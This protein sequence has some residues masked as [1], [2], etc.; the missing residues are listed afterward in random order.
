MKFTINN[1]HYQ[2]W[3]R[4]KEKLSELNEFLN[5]ELETAD[6]NLIPSHSGNIVPKRITMMDNLME[7][8]TNYILV[9]D[10][11]GDEYYT[12]KLDDVVPINE[13]VEDWDYL[14]TN[15]TVTIIKSPQEAIVDFIL[16]ESEFPLSILYDHRNKEEWENLL[17]GLTVKTLNAVSGPIYD[18]DELNPGQERLVNDSIY[19]VRKLEELRD[20]TDYIMG[21]Q[22][23]Y[24]N[25]VGPHKIKRTK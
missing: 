10:I 12:A 16:N 8:L 23:D 3:F 4:F 5:Q 19:T 17:K 7:C 20:F 9:K 18:L 22:T 15:G 2:T 21:E 11:S 24:Y 6:L 13:V 25:K 14:V 1:D